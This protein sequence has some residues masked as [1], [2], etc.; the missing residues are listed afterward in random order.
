[1]IGFT[2]NFSNSELKL[3][4]IGVVVPIPTDRLGTTFIFIISFSS[5]LWVVVLAADTLVVTVVV[6]L[7]ISPVTC[8]KL[9][10]KKYVPE[11]IPE[12]DPF[13]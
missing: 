6:T 13:E 8:S 11:L 4:E 12:V 2:N 3:I 10:V 5:K 1:M 9:E 7:S